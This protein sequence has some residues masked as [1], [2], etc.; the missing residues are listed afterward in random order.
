[1]KSVI[2]A[3]G[4]GSRL[5]GLIGNFNKHLLPVGEIPLIT[6]S[7][8]QLYKGGIDEFIIMTDRE[9][10]DSFRSLFDK[11][12]I[13]NKEIMS[14]IK[15]KACK[16]KGLPL[17]D[18]LNEASSFIGQEDFILFLGD[19][20]FIDSIDILIKKLINTTNI[21]SIVLSKTFSPSNF[22][23]PT[24]VD[25]KIKEIIEKPINPFGNLVVTGIAKYENEIYEIIRFLIK[26]DTPNRDLTTLHNILIKNNKLDYIVWTGRWFDIGTVESYK[27]ALITL[28][29][30]YK[31]LL[32]FSHNQLISNML[33][34]YKIYNKILSLYEEINNE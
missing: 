14:S 26:N 3:G 21:N 10:I 28:R 7:I 30:S 9:W 1:M 34:E 5:S 22:G 25:S 20:L 2:F 24:I 19:N 4:I 31:K 18:I 23:V 32:S 16:G 15:I 27:M 11:Q 13:T 6:R 17:L 12:R 33:K 29:E 8:S